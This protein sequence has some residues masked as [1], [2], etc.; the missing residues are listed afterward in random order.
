MRQINTVRACSKRQRSRLNSVSATLPEVKTYLRGQEADAFNR[1]SAIVALEAATERQD[2][3]KIAEIQEQLTKE[4]GET[5]ESARGLTLE[6]V[7]RDAEYAEEL[8]QT[9]NEKNPHFE[10]V[11]WRFTWQSGYSFSARRLEDVSQCQRNR[12]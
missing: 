11:R 9:F 10:S 5:E 8:F 1:V 3:K 4:F 2:S 12:P 7:V 6:Q